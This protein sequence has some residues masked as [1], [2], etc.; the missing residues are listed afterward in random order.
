[1]IDIIDRLK[2]SDISPQGAIL[3]MRACV[4]GV[5]IAIMLQGGSIGR[6]FTRISAYWPVLTTYS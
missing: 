1:M 5:S 6:Q 4:V 2:R 3:S